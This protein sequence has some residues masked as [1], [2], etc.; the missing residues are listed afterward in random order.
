ML[1]DY[2]QRTQFVYNNE[3]VAEKQSTDPKNTEQRDADDKNSEMD[4]GSTSHKVES[5]KFD[6]SNDV[7]PESLSSVWVP[8]EADFIK[9]D[10]KAGLKK[11]SG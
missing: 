8:S 10:K 6:S 1:E 9:D 3:I 2:V 5:N 4:I 11:L 7:M